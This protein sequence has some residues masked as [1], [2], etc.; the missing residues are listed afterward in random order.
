MQTLR[1]AAAAL[2]QTPLDWKGNVAR[3]RAVLADAR[4]NEV[5]V[6]CMPELVTTGY[7][8]EDAFHSLDTIARAWD[9]LVSVVADTKGLVACIGL[10]VLHRGGIYNAVA[11]VADTRIVALGAKSHL[12]GDGIHYEPRWFK[13]WP[14]EVTA[15]FRHGELA[16][17]IGDM[18]IELGG[19][20]YGFEICEDAW[21]AAR[22]A[23][24]LA[25][26]GVDVVLNPSASHFALGKQA[27]RRNIVEEG[28]RAFGV[29]YV[30]ANL[31]GN[32]AGRAI[33]DGSCLIASD[34][35]LVAESPRFSMREHTLVCADVDISLTRARRA[36]TAS[37]LPDVRDPVYEV[38]VEHDYAALHTPC[39]KPGAPSFPETREE[40][41]ARAL[42]TGLFDYLRKSRARGYVVSLS[43]G[44]DSSAC[45]CLV[46]LFV[47]FALHELGVEGT[48]RALPSLANVHGDARAMTAALLTTMY[49]STRN[50]GDVTRNAARTVAHAVGSTHLELDVDALVQTY[51]STVETAIGRPLTWQTDDVA[52]QNVQARVR[53]PSAW[54]V[55][56][57]EGKLLITTSN[58]SEA[59]VGY[60]TMDGDTAGGLSPLSGVSKAYLR[61]WLVWLEH[62]GPSGLGPIPEL[63]V[64][65]VQAP[66]AELRPSEAKQTDED[67]LMPYD[68]LELIEQAA[69]R[70][71]RPPL[72]VLYVLRAAKPD[73]PED[74]RR[75][76]VKRFHRLFAQNQWK[77][78]RYAPGFHVDDENLD[79]K[80]WCRFPI[81]SGNFE[82]EL[83]DLDA[84][85]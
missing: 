17:P 72:D 25:A 2:R 48:K 35:V 49:Q 54:L 52:M 59:A 62:T 32:E 21:V 84:L 81:L 8:C 15:T 28:A 74:V 76:W 40:E 19:V 75:A 6:V 79:P 7:G 30:Y 73:V 68:V 63:R 16:I 61:K 41:L 83:E 26:Q 11:V 5:H 12:A 23:A 37:A 9:A 82:A 55:A 57:I 58:R 29:T 67:D 85:P 38:R 50:S 27:V 18:P 45:A 3:M 4:A 42:S 33:Y 14:D 24:R 60:A 39:P 46:G 43:G 20:R 1:V 34:G 80:T 64:V 78:E 56:N 66:T 13:A 70:D 22:P 53:A 77:R 69:I 71:K 51:M 65:N 44:A 31:L 36:R 10:P 47:R